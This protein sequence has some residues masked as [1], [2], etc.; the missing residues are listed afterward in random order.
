MQA[1]N[2][3]SMRRSVG[4]DYCAIALQQRGLQHNPP[5]SG[6]KADMAGCQFYA[7]SQTFAALPHSLIYKGLVAELKVADCK[8]HERIGRPRDVTLATSCE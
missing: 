8:S 7:I 6:L 3:D 5:D 2:I 4:F 1:R